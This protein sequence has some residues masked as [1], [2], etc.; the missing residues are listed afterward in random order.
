M[1]LAPLHIYTGC[2]RWHFAARRRLA[3]WFGGYLALCTIGAG[4]PRRWFAFRR[5]IARDR[6]CPVR[7]RPALDW[8]P[9]DPYCTP[10]D[11]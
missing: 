6:A 9:A 7:P 3:P 11:P 5:I 2:T 4:R 1:R 8:T 10:F